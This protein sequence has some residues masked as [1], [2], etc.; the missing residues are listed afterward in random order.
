MRR[1]KLLLWKPLVKQYVGYNLFLHFIVF[2]QEDKISNYF[3]VGVAKIILKAQ[4][5]PSLKCI[6]ANIITKY[7]IPYY[8]MVPKDLE[9]FI[10]LHGICKYLPILFVLCFENLL[11]FINLRLTYLINFQCRRRV[12]IKLIFPNKIYLGY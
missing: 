9:T 3:D 7:K 2:C 12:D 10:D 1:V 11:K 6:A 5:K 4:M 8:G